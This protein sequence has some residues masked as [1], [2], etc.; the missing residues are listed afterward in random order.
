VP[1]TITPPTSSTPATLSA[2]SPLAAQIAQFIEDDDNVELRALLMTQMLPCVAE[3]SGISGP[4]CPPN[5]TIGAEVEA[6]FTAGCQGGWTTE[7]DELAVTIVELAGSP[8]AL[9][10]L[11][12]R[13][14]DWPGDVPYGEM[15]LVFFPAGSDQTSGVAVYVD[16]N[17]IARTQI[18]CK[19]A[20]DFLLNGSGGELPILW[21]AQ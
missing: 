19:P 13:T 18:D 10:E 17:A 7:V 15:V 14:A 2:A 12:P 11:E 8:M 3:D 21:Q 6:A 9:A 1:T 16:E 4:F 5:V 20:E